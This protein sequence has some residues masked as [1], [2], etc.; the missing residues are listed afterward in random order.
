M[1]LLRVYELLFFIQMGRVYTRTVIGDT[2]TFLGIGEKIP[3]ACA[4]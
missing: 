3:Q 2:T 1:M 4:N